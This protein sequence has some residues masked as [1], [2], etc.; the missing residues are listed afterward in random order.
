MPLPKKRKGQKQ[1]KFMNACMS[2]SVMKK[3]F[4]DPTQRVAVCLRRA[5][6]PKKGAKK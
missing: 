1:G 3:E 6:V 4:P 5:G 2:S